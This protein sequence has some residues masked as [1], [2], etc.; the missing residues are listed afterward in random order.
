MPDPTPLITPEERAALK[1]RTAQYVRLAGGVDVFA[2]DAGVAK[3]QLSKYG[4]ASEPDCVIRLDVAVALDRRLEAPMLIGE[5]ARLLGYRLV[6]IE[7]DAPEPVSHAD[8]ARIAREGSDVVGTLAEGLK[9]GHLDSHE[10][11]ATREQIGENIL[12]LQ[13]LDRKLSGGGA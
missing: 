7:P 4:S 1:T 13:H 12:V 3:A 10:R 5:A 9:D 6:P 11:R 8:L 2:F